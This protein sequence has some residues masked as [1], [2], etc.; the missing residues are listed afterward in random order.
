LIA[1]ELN[2]LLQIEIRENSSLS[3]GKCLAIDEDEHPQG[4]TAS[5]G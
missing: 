5:F 4:V 3:G 2:I 1:V